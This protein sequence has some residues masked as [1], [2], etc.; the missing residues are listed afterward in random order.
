MEIERGNRAKA[1]KQRQLL[2]R[3]LE[4]IGEKLEESGNAT[5]TQ[6]QKKRE[7][8]GWHGHVLGPRPWEKGAYCLHFQLEKGNKWT[9]ST[10]L[11]M[12]RPN[13]M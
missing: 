10:I 2:S 7:R 5:A 8:S 4:E 9:N 3:E 12:Y 13:R 6:G 11:G 1:E